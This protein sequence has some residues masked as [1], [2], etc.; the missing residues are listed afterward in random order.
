M[1][2]KELVVLMAEDSKHDRLATERAW[3]ELNIT[4]QLVIVNNGEEVLDYLYHRGKFSEPGAASRPGIILLDIKMPRVDGIEVL[5]QIRE[6][7]EFHQLPVIMLTSSKMEEDR[8]RSYDL[9]ATAYIVKPLDYDNFTA[10]IK[11]I[12]VFWMLVELPE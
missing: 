12:N 1:K 2:K 8:V 4:N 11:A 6:S 9:G 7:D 5:K 3:E 10:A